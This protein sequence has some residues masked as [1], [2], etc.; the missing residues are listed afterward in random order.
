MAETRSGQPGVPLSDLPADEKATRSGSFGEVA[1]HY[2]RFRPGPP[3]TAVDWLLPDRV[4]RVVDLGAG[5]GALTRLLL[6]RALEVV[7]VEPDDRMRSVLLHEVPA[8]RAMPGRGEAMSLPD[9]YADAV[10]ASSSWHWMDPIPALHEVGRI[11]KPNGILGALW[12]GPDPEGPFMVQAQAVLAEQSQPD[13]A[14]QPGG[15]VT[16]LMLGDVLRPVSTLE[17]PSH[18]PFEQPE[19]RAFTWDVAL[20]ADE[21]IGL[22]GTL[23]WVITMPDETRSSLFGE[24]RRLLRDLLGIEGDVAVDVAFRS[25]VWRTTRIDG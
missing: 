25:D 4:E 13:N 20:N 24:A 1:S 6:E 11:L 12:T 22:L 15:V 10:L 2:D 19:Y 14:G 8:A 5:T 18:V 21:L 7:A 9:G 16:D 3:V 17:I 23:S